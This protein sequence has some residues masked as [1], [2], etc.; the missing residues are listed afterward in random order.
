M[1][2]DPSVCYATVLSRHNTMER[3]DG[4]PYSAADYQENGD[5]YRNIFA[6]QVK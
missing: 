2:S 3:I 6:E 4:K 1:P 5:M